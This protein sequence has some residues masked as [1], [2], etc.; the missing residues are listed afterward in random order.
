[1]CDFDGLEEV[2]RTVSFALICSFCV[3]RRRGTNLYLY[4]HSH[5]ES[6]LGV[7]LPQA[8]NITDMYGFSLGTCLAGVFVLLRQLSIKNKISFIGSTRLDRCC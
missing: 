7:L 1:M 5:P 3:N 2:L 8:S 4:D 6:R